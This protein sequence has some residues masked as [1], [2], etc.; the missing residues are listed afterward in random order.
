MLKAEINCFGKAKYGKG[1]LKAFK[2]SP[3]LPGFFTL[4][5]SVLQRGHLLTFLYKRDSHFRDEIM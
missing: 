4:H 5:H 1:K 3:N 2:K